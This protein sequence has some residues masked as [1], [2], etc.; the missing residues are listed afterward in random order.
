MAEDIGDIEKYT[1]ADLLVRISDLT[2]RVDELEAKQRDY[3]GR[4]LAALSQLTSYVSKWKHPVSRIVVTLSVVLS[5]A[6]NQL[7]YLLSL[8]D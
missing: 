3:N 2:R 6:I 8:L 7:P 4:F 1:K 5:T